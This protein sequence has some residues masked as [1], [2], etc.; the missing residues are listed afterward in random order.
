MQYL[1]DC[2]SGLLYTGSVVSGSLAGESCA[3][4]SGDVLQD[5]S[6]LNCERDG[7][8]SACDSIEPDSLLNRKTREMPPL[9]SVPSF[10]DQE[11]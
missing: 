5:D 7:V 8:E 6:A 10:G 3:Y 4:V 11:V 1:H 9:L 2:R